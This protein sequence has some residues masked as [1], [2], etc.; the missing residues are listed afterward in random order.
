MVTSVG[1]IIYIMAIMV[2]SYH[3]KTLK[4]K[5]GN[6]DRLLFTKKDKI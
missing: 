6:L 2:N 3:F 1:I 5:I 4:G